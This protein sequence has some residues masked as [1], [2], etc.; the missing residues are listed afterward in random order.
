LSWLGL[1]LLVFIIWWLLF[2][3]FVIPTDS[4]YPTLNGD[5]RIL[6]GDRIFV[7]KLIYGPR[8]PFTNIRLWR[9]KEPQR[10]DI[11]VF[12]PV[13]KD[14]DHPVLIKRVVGLPGER[15]QIKDGEV[16][17]NGEPIEPPGHLRDVLH[18]TRYLGDVEDDLMRL[19]IALTAN[20][21]PPDEDFKNLSRSSLIKMDK[22]QLSSMYKRVPDWIKDAARAQVDQQVPNPLIYGVR[23]E[24]EYSVVP[25]DS[26]LVLG[27]NSPHSADGRVFGWV[28]NGNILGRA[29]CA[30]WPIGRAQDFTGFWH[31]WPGKTILYGTPV[32]IVLIEVFAHVRRKRKQRRQA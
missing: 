24:D 25:E 12:R 27:D 31:A 2:Q 4:M 22:K 14:A 26:Y 17:V 15:I 10:W 3:P 29:T 19:A 9:F 18:Y 30:F 1:T 16:W 8:I 23:P 28:P 13:G 20:S 21:E 11:V 5:E 6:R 32:L 7:N